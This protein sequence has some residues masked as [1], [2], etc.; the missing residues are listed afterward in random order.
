M[1]SL[2]D[3][4]DRLRGFDLERKL[5]LRPEHPAMALEIDRSALTLVR[6]KAKRRGRPQLESFRVQ[7]LAAEQFPTTISASP[8]TEL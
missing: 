1:A 2:S 8:L 7:T 4:L 6:L 3:M 5:G